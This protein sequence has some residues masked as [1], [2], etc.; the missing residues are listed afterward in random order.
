M[1][2]CANN[3]W[4]T[5]AGQKWEKGAKKA[6]SGQGWPKIDLEQPKVGNR[7]KSGLKWPEANKKR[8]TKRGNRGQKYFWWPR[9][10]Q[11]EVAK[12]NLGKWKIASSVPK[13]PNAAKAAKRGQQRQ[14]CYKLHCMVRTYACFYWHTPLMADY[15]PTRANQ[16]W[17]GWPEPIRTPKK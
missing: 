9:N 15:L 12:N 10:H 16:D 1:F 14:I 5:I 8:Q 7:S 11:P 13:W 4:I 2:F 17:Q 3:N 6:K